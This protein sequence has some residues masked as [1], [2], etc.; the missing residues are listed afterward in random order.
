M[1]A[2]SLFLPVFVLRAS[3]VHTLTI[4]SFDVARALR[5]TGGVA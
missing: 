4:T 5:G 1:T 2:T 3:T